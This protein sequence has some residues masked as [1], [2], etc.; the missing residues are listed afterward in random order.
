MSSNLKAQSSW[1]E[2][3]TP[4]LDGQPVEVAIIIHFNHQ[5]FSTGLSD[6]VVGVFEVWRHHETNANEIKN[7]L[8]TLSAGCR[9]R[10][11]PMNRASD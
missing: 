4:A 10:E 2:P 8:Q 5:V 9:T 1:G 6:P 3:S 7:L 11:M